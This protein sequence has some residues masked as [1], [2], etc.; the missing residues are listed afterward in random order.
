MSNHNFA[1]IIRQSAARSPSSTAM[2]A[3][4]RTITYEQLVRRVNQSGNLF[5]SQG[6]QPGD[7]VAV[8][9]VNDYRF[10]EIC[11]GLMSAGAVP[12]PM[13]SK[14]GHEA[15]TYVYRD[16]GSRMLVYHVSLAEKAKA[17]KQ[18]AGVTASIVC[19]ADEDERAAAD[20]S[21]LVYDELLAIQSPELELY[22]AQPDD[23]CLLPYTS[24]STGNPKGCRLTHRGQ[25]WNVSAIAGTRE[26]APKDRIVISLPLYHKNAMLSMKAVF[27]SGS[28]A[29]ILPAPDP[30]AI[31]QAIETHR[32]TY[33]SGVPAL[34]RMLTG[35][36]KESSSAYDLSSLQYA[37]C[38]S[39][40]TPVELLEEIRLRMGVEVYEG[41][42]LTEGGPVVLESRKGLHKAGSAGIPLPGG[43]IRIVDAGRRPVPNGEVGELWVNNPGV[44]DGYWNLPEVTRERITP[45]GWLKTGDMAWQD[46][47][48]FV[49]IVGRKDDMINVGGENVYPKE[50]EN[51]LLQHP[52]IEDAC[53]LPA[54][55]PLKGEVP[56]AFIITRGEVGHEEIKRFFIERGPAYA[57]PREIFNLASFPLT[58]PGKVDRTALKRLLAEI[59][60]KEERT[61][62]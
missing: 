13:N 54:A 15:L 22:P 16:S 6:I 50:V 25:R 20:G 32:C 57:H 46:D 10:L 21:E 31:L 17:V 9:F 11:F 3:G 38:G 30:A 18:N 12:V 62:K 42:G 1:D 45:D 34:Y 33:I 28:S 59:L 60:H 14:L 24:G 37:I 41:Y 19:L 35:H 55:H 52:G 48:G 53:V 40:D 7:R 43:N 51:I 36:L 49:F 4:K 61:M 56:V 2:I 44:A 29:V 23:L 5:A 47:E 58:G 26:L 39:S 8:L 27:Y